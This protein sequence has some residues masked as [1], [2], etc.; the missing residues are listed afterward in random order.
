MLSP[1]TILLASLLLSVAPSAH[2]HGGVNAVA[3]DRSW[4]ELHGALPPPDAGEGE[5]ITTHLA[6]VEARLRAAS[7]DH[8]TL[9]Q[10]R[11]RL[12]LLDALHAYTAA[13]A[14]PRRDDGVPGRRPRFVDAEG[15]H[16]AVAHLVRASAGPSLVSAVQRA[17]ADDYVM[18]MQVPAL[19]AW[20]SRSGFTIEELALIQPTYDDGSGPEMPPEETPRERAARR[21]REARVPRDLTARHVQRVLRSY[22]TFNVLHVCLGERTGHFQ[23]R[24]TLAVGRGRPLRAD[25]EIRDASDGRRQRAIERCFG[26]A[27]KTAMRAFIA[28]A[29]HVL[30]RR[31]AESHEAPLDVHTPAEIEATYLADR[32]PF[33]RALVEGGP[34]TREACLRDWPGEGPIEVPLTISGGHGEVQ[35]RWPELASP[36]STFD[37]DTEARWYCL[38]RVLG[39]NA[40]RV[41]GLRDH[42]FTVLIERDGTM[43]VRAAASP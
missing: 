26:R 14:F 2:A 10:R 1:K 3:G 24:T 25:V 31:L 43:R 13:R 4:I 32:Q 6:W 22:A 21:A 8:L 40:R 23:V 41:H 17:H 33:V 18:D 35:I 27:A 12:A 38:R 34:E 39:N 19:A 20:A 5:R 28:S 9:T 37:V 30:P 36:P 7:V 11:A 42:R 15:R 16:C 29:N